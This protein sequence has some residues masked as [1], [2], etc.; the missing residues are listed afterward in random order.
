M[1]SH[2]GGLTHPEGD[3]KRLR[4]MTPPTTHASAA[5]HRPL[6]TRAEADHLIERNICS[7]RC[8]CAVMPMSA[9]RLDGADVRRQLVRR[10]SVT[11]RSAVKPAAV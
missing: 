11:S 3:R 4:A 8:P 6:V 9:Y 1:R 5:S 7:C 10:K 2:L